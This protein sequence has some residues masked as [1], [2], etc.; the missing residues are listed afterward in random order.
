MLKK[1][2][3]VYKDGGLYSVFMKSLEFTAR[4]ARNWLKTIY[5]KASPAGTFNFNG[6]ALKYF[7]HNFNLAYDNERTV[8]VAVVGAFLKSLGTQARI[9]E[10]G[11]VLIHYG[12]R[13]AGRDVLDKYDPAQYVI[14][15]DVI[16]FKPAKKYDAIISISTLEHVGWDEEVRD[17]VKI[18]TAVRNLTENCLAP[19]GCMLVTIPLGYNPY[20]DDQLAEGARYFTE[21]YFL[22]RISSDNDWLQV[23]YSEVAGSKFGQPFNNANA[24]CIGI[25]RA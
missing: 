24:M 20:F 11:N 9:L 23:D 10:V 7:R 3:R 2:R 6:S 14:N 17:P 25:V 13:N 4:G 1:L 18:I 21:K 5:F 15:E 12:F 19:G 22:K 8:E 16:S